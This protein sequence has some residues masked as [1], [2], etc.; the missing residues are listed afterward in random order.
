VNAGL[1]RTFAAGTTTIGVN[2][3]GNTATTTLTAN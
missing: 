1:A 2:R 3:G